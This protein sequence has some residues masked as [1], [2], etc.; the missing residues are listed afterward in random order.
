VDGYGKGRPKPKQPGKT[1]SPYYQA[2][3]AGGYGNPPVSGQKKKGGPGG[4]GRPKGQ[5]SLEAA[6]QRVLRKKR[7]V[8]RD[9]KVELLHPSDIMAERILEA[10]L[11]KN[12][13]PTM[14]ELARRI[15]E[16]SGP[17][18][19]EKEEQTIAW[20]SF[21]DDELHLFGGLLVRASG[22]EPQE[23]YVSPFGRKYDRKTEGYY[24]VTRR[25]D[26]H[27]VVEKIADTESQMALPPPLTT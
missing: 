10:L 17:Q 8:V 26:G 14:I 19:L 23:N 13:S 24:C 5:T 21:S 11:A 9:G 16:R 7:T 25:S 6:L 3:N 20:R 4:P 22:G 12:L 18:M 2:N 27:I 15:M 1:Y